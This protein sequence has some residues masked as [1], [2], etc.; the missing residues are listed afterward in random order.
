MTRDTTSRPLYYGYE[1]VCVYYSYM[2]KTT[3]NPKSYHLIVNILLR[4][5]LGF[6]D[7]DDLISLPRSHRNATGRTSIDLSLHLNGVI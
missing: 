7:D 5:V 6:T 2:S 1:P 4:A 3:D